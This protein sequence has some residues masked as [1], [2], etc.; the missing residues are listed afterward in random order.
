MNTVMASFNT[1]S[2]KWPKCLS[3]KK[4]RVGW[5]DL[6]HCLSPPWC[7]ASRTIRDCWKSSRYIESSEAAAP[8]TLVK[9]KVGMKLNE[10]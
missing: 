5:L 4:N 3:E 2:D 9:G 1:L 8:A 7:G 6:R 10:W